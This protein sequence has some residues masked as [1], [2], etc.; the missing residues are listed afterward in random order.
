MLPS[1]KAV[2]PGSFDPPTL[3][4]VSVVKRALNVFDKIIVA[5]AYNPGKKT[6]FTVDE[7]LE[8]LRDSLAAFPASR[9]EVDFFQ[10]LTV[11][12]ARSQGARAV[13]RGLRVLADFDFEFQLAM[14]NNHID[15]DIQSVFLM[16]DHQWFFV[17]SSIVK[18]A[19]MFGADVDKLVSPL[20]AEKLK[21]KFDR[22]AKSHLI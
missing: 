12:Y 6:L 2:Y 17:S 20:V 19:A 21:A 10:G 13:L 5:V 8:L 16:A 15:H 22:S 14:M 4:H 3:G 1:H 7:R 9:V 18:E 11:D